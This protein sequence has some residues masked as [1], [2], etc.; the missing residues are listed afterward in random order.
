MRLISLKITHRFVFLIFV[1]HFRYPSNYSTTFFLLKYMEPFKPICVS[2]YNVYNQRLPSERKMNKC[3]FFYQR[4]IFYTYIHCFSDVHKLLILKID[5]INT[6]NSTRPAC[7]NYLLKSKYWCCLKHC[8]AVC[9]ALNDS[10]KMAKHKTYF[11]HRKSR[12]VS[13]PSSMIYSIILTHMHASDLW[14]P[15]FQFNWWMF[16]CGIHMR[17]FLCICVCV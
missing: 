5:W 13:K 7:F 3:D 11:S 2:T 17:V 1:A 6:K 15:I 8:C 16:S 4:P 10:V 9:N 14:I 12:I